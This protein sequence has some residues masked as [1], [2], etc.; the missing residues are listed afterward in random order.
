MI[1]SAWGDE[2]DRLIAQGKVLLNIHCKKSFLIYE[3]LRC[4]RWLFAGMPV[5][6][7]NV[8]LA[9]EIDVTPLMFLCEYDQLVETVAMVLENYPACKERSRELIPEIAAKRKEYL[10]AFTQYLHQGAF[11]APAKK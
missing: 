2:R 7:E 4:D 3:S 9:D 5:V 1:V 11:S 6:S 8:P 10:K